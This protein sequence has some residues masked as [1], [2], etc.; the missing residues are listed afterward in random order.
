MNIKKIISVVTLFCSLT[1]V[2]SLQLPLFQGSLGKLEDAYYA[3]DSNKYGKALEYVEEAK[4]IRKKEVDDYLS[5]LNK[6]LSPYAV[7]EVGDRIPAVLSVLESREDYDA[8]NLIKYLVDLKGASYFNNSVNEVQKY[9]TLKELMPEASYLIGHIYEYEGEYDLAVKYYT[10]AWNNSHVLEIPDSKY[11]ILY[12]LAKLSFNFNKF[13]ESEKSL[14][15]IIA[16]DSNFK[17]VAF[18]RAIISSVEKGYSADKIFN[19]YRT[20]CYRSITAFFLLSDLYSE[21]GKNQQVF[22]MALYGVLTSFTR[23]N[24]ILQSRRVDY[25]YT[26]LHEF[27][28]IAMQNAEIKQWTID[29]NFWKAF[30]RLADVATEL[31]PE[32]GDF[33][34]I[35]MEVIYLHAPETYWKNL[36][37]IKLSK[38]LIN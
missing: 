18:K 30:Y 6:S 33:G 38:N 3:F 12:D 7:K 31:Y 1:F 2:F 8:H 27:F 28:K 10:S 11:D 34:P 9:L 21:K 23:M 15:L 14:L 25:T 20:D 37:G 19:L 36:A 26:T 32:N 4:Q 29:I 16:S 35:L 13:E 5:I 17:D 24:E 22:E